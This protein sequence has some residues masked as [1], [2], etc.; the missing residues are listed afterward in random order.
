ML[1]HLTVEQTRA[2][3]ALAALCSLLLDPHA[4]KQTLCVNFCNC[5]FFFLLLIITMI[6]CLN[7]TGIKSKVLA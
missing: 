2:F 5:I 4:W 6:I 3:I 7:C 1:G